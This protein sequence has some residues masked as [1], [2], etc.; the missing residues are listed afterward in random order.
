MSQIFY[1]FPSPPIMSLFLYI[2]T[3][4]CYFTFFNNSHFSGYEVVSRCD[5]DMHFSRNTFS[6]ECWIF[7]YILRRNVY[8]NSLSIFNWSFVFFLLNCESSFYI[9]DTKFLSDTRFKIFPSS[10]DFLFTL[11]MFFHIHYFFLIYILMYLFLFCCLCF[12]YYIRVHCPTWG[13]ED[14]P[15]FSSSGF[16]VLVLMFM[17]FICSKLTFA[18]RIR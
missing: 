15:M 7:V 9:P 12:W 2:F 8:S 11:L 4:T 17:L 14:L 16:I 3:N 10:L 18:H 5:L 1:P 13:N 6:C